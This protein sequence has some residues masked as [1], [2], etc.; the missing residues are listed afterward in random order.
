MT[1]VN[2][3]KEDPEDN[4]VPADNQDRRESQDN[5]DLMADQDLQVRCAPFTLRCSDKSRDPRVFCE[6][7]KKNR[8]RCN[9]FP[10]TAGV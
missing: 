1:K 9:C 4:V 8:S 3:E 5:Q 10:L 7:C 2:L 6:A